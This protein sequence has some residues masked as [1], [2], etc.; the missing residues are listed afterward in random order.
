MD[1]IFKS[2]AADEGEAI[3]YA[4]GKKLS[5][6]PHIISLIA[7]HFIKLT[8]LP[9]HTDSKV[10]NYH[11]PVQYN[12][13]TQFYDRTYTLTEG[14]SYQAIALDL[15][16]HEGLNKDIMAYAQSYLSSHN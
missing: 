12:Q 11:L 9:E 8:T 2:T 15:M 3:A 10:T 14:P 13:S 7:T 1:E 5:D 6:M 4:L 16:K